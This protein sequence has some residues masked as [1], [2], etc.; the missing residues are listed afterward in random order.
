M[1]EVEYLF[2]QKYIFI[3][4][5]N[6]DII[7]GAGDIQNTL[8][9]QEWRFSAEGREIQYIK[10]VAPTREQITEDNGDIIAEVSC[11]AE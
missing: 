8:C 10:A 9:F 11:K 7:F 3:I 6:L 2:I 1:A 4:F 5:C